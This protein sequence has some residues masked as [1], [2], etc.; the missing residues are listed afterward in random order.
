MNET[1]SS[2]RRFLV[3][4]AVAASAVPLGAGLL[5]GKAMAQDLPALPVDNAQAKALGYTD[6]AATQKHPNFKAGSDCAN[7]TSF[8]GAP[9]ARSGPS[10]FFPGPPAQAKDWK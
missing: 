3:N 8:H 4:L 7:C 1:P 9:G 6:D 5:S 10:A 2:R